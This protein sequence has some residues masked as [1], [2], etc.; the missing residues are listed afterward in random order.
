M[1]KGTRLQRTT[2]QL[3][4]NGPVYEQLARALKR[5]ILKGQIAPGKHLP[6][7]RVLAATLGLSRNT[8]LGAYELLRTEQLVTT[9]DRSGTRVAEG[10]GLIN[11]PHGPATTRAQSRYAARLRKLAPPALGAIKAQPR[12][13]LHY[14]EPLS[15]PRLFHSWRRRV[16]AAALL[17]GPRYPDA[18][19]F[20]PLR[21]AICEYLARRR[22]V[23]CTEQD[24]L[25]VGGTQQAASLVAR[26]V[27]DEGD[28]A[29]IEEPHYQFVMQ[30]LEAHG[31][32][33]VHVRTDADGL[34]TSELAK[35]RPRLVC[36]TPSHQFPSGSVLSLA[37]RMELLNIASRQ[38]SWIL[39]DDYDSEFQYR[40]RSIAALRSLDLS[41]RVIYVGSFSKTL[42][43]SLRLGY[44]VCPP[45]I[46][47]DLHQAKRMDDLGSPAIEQAALA[48]FMQS[49][50]FEKH[51]GK[52]VAELD[53]R[54]RVL[55]NGLREHAGDR[56][57]IQ[58]TQ[59]GVHIVVWFRR[60]DYARLD[61]LIALG[62][63]LGL[64]LYPIHPHYRRLPP[65]PGLLLGY[66]GLSAHSLEA[67]CRI[68]GECLDQ[69]EAR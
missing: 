57:E 60:M 27:L 14:G 66:A 3:D 21:R 36:V 31:A 22:G 11:P 41:G 50:Q 33:L 5:A 51:L 8:V 68:F 46:R 44:I 54:R 2:Y 17:A 69:L 61:R 40:G 12:Y 28:S 43:P 16:A 35:H 64:G 4:G 10:A 55:I 53:R 34:V 56:I 26:V 13:D 47:E 45:G 37:R 59:A 19:G 52:T 6:A 38:D 42:F 20:L 65:R 49:H 7:T 23:E 48:T 29:A 62:I 58:D 39:E 32:R 67:A 25:I 18:A 15:D 30:T 24:V 63:K 9:H 1:K